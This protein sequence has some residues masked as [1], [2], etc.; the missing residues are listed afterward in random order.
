[1]SEI[2]WSLSDDELA[3]ILLAHPVT[4]DFFFGHPAGDLLVGRNGAPQDPARYARIFALAAARASDPA[5]RLAC[6][7]EEWNG[8]RRP[9]NAAPH[10]EVA[11]VYAS[12]RDK[13]A[14]EVPSGE[15]KAVLGGSIGYNLGIVLHGLWRY[16]EAGNSQL[17]SASW[18]ILAGRQDKAL[19]ALFVAA[20]DHASHALVKGEPTQIAEQLEHLRR[21][22]AIVRKE[23]SPYPRW[24]VENAAWH[25]W[26][27]HLMAEVDYP[28]RG[29]D[30]ELLRAGEFPPAY[31]PWQRLL[32]VSEIGDR[33]SQ[34]AAADA[35]LASPEMVQLS[36]ADVVLA[37]KLCKAWTMLELRQTEGARE[38]LTEITGWTGVA[39]GV[40]M[41]VAAR[42]LATLK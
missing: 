19:V 35:A 3:D 30:L 33:V 17:V 34:I 26:W 25:I 20:V 15:V 16:L 23:V 12:L 29:S 41:A 42:V 37:I 9:P 14:Q 18:L 4:T 5:M 31:A 27:A 40:P 2:N 39:G 13:L 36:Y 38:I 21:M 11:S 24:M 7:V 32:E 1:M 6:L 8:R 28:E 22:R 10:Y